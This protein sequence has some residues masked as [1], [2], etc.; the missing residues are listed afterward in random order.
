MARVR[1]LAENGRMIISTP[2]A[3]SKYGQWCRYADFT[4][5]QIFDAN[6]I[7]Q[8][9]IAAGFR[10]SKVLPFG[11]V[12]RGPASAARWLLWQ[13]W[14]PL[15]KLSLAVES[16]WERGQVFTPNLIAIADK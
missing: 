4:H 8:C 11:P 3:M 13:V 10:H 6:S 15:L 5:Q 7:R 14:E 9:L 12:V 16:G 1:G 2:N